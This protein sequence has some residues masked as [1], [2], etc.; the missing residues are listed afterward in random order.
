MLVPSVVLALAS[1]VILVGSGVELRASIRQRRDTVSRDD[2]MSHL[3]AVRPF[4]ILTWVGLAAVALLAPALV[5]P[6]SLPLGD[7]ALVVVVLG[8]AAERAAY[9][10]GVWGSSANRAVRVA[11]VAVSVVVGGLAVALAT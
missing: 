2:A 7:A 8:F 6:S 3:L 11:V 1:V 10:V 9:L 4:A 5:R